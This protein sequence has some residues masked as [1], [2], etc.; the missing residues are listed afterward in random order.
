MK[1]KERGSPQSEEL[2]RLLKE[3]R[4]Q[5]GLTQRQLA[6]RVG[7]DHKVISNLES[8]SKRMT[9]LELIALAAAL[10]FDAPAA[11]RRVMKK[12]A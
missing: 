4:F 2:R 10:E 11:L 7:W 8:G 9:V 3:R 5:A 6:E 12:P 1:Q